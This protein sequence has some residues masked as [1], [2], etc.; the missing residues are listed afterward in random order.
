MAS[1]QA[2]PVVDIAIMTITN[3]LA[4]W[5]QAVY[6]CPHCKS[7]TCVSAAG[8]M[9]TDEDKAALQNDTE[10]L[11]R[12]K[13]GVVVQAKCSACEGW[14]SGRMPEKPLV[15]VA[16]AMPAI[17]SGAAKWHPLVTLDRRN[18]TPAGGR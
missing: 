5:E 18:G 11:M 3:N 17:K 9:V 16:K 13:N 8:P 15:Q 2:E 4:K 12:V 6:R 1:E 10:F 14:F 7:V